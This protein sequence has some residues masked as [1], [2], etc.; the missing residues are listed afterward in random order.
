MSQLRLTIEYQPKGFFARQ[1]HGGKLHID[2]VD[3]PGEWLLDLPLMKLSYSEWS[4]ATL[5][6]SKVEPR[7]KSR[8]GM[9]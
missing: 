2:I 6:S 7:G 4:K 5:A 9:A 3:Y 8:Q 1:T